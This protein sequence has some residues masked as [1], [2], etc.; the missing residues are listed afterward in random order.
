MAST[1]S[2]LEADM[3]GR[4]PE[5]KP[6]MAAMAVPMNIFQGESTNSKSPV[7]EDA[8]SEARNTYSKPISPPMM[9]RITASNRN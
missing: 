9:A 7:N 8:M 6:I 2:S 4:I 1:G 3:A 5:I